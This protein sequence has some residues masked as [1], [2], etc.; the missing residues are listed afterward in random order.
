MIRRNRPLVLL[1]AATL[2]FLSGMFSLSTVGVFYARDVLGNADYYIAMTAVQTLAMV[3]AAALVPAA[4]ARLGKKRTYVLAGLVAA[5][6]AL[7]FAL[8]PG[9]VPALG[10]AF[11]GALGIGFGAINALVFAFQADTVEYGEWESGVRAEGASYAVLSF[12]RKAGQGIGG[13]VAAYTIGLG[14]YVSGS[15][16]QTDTAVTSIRVA[17]GIVPAVAVAAATLVMLAYPLS[18]KAFRG[19][20]AEL[21]ERRAARAISAAS[22]P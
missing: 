18:E 13:A 11:Y 5:V 20:V 15:A 8:A 1:C 2:L 22:G 16:A 17:A 10:I 14:G 3:A 9:S 6:S 12:T 4:V 19:L 7:A 21:A